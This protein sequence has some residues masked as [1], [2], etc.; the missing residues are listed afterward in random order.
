MQIPYNRFEVLLQ[1][2]DYSAK[3][4]HDL[5][6]PHLFLFYFLHRNSTTLKNIYSALPSFI[7]RMPISKAF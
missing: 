2:Q 3:Q 7:N 6:I 5:D 1:C 4:D